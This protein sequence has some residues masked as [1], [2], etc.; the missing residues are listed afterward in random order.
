ML[1]GFKQI[2]IPLSGGDDEFF[3]IAATNCDLELSS[4]CCAEDSILPRGWQ[5]VRS[6]DKLPPI[7]IIEQ[8]GNF[9]VRLYETFPYD[10][11]TEVDDHS[12]D[13][14]SPLSDAG[15]RHWK[16]RK[17]KKSSPSGS[18]QVVNHLGSSFI[19]LGKDDWSQ[20]IPLEFIS[21]KL[22]FDVEY[23]KMTEDIAAFCE[24]LLLSATNPTSLK[25]S[26]NPDE[27][28]RLLLESF[29]FLRHFLTP[30]K[31]QSLIEHIHRNPHSSLVSERE[32][33]PIGRVRSSQHLSQPDKMLRDWRG[34]AGNLRP[35]EA[36]NVHRQESHNTPPNQFLK[37]AL[38]HFRKITQDILDNY[39]QESTIGREAEEL[40]DTLD[41]TL[42]QPF[43]RS[44][45]RLQ[46]L[47]LNNQT[48]Q[49]REGYRDV[50]RA[51]ILVESACSLDWAGQKDCFDGSTRDVATLYEYW[52]FLEI[53]KILE[54]IDGMNRL[55]GA[56]IAD[57]ASSFINEKNGAI[58]LN[59]QSGKHSLSSFEFKPHDES[60]GL[61]IDL[62]YER[63]FFKES[64]DKY[65]DAATSIASYSRQF[66]PDYTLAIFPSRFADEKRAAEVGKVAHL[67]FDAKY[68]ASKLKEMFGGKGS[69]ELS[70]EKKAVKSTSTY[71]RGDLLKMHTYNDALRKTIGSYVLYPGDG[72]G[73]KDSFNKFHE[74]A[75]SV[76]ALVMKPG[77]ETC[78]DT[79]KS[80]LLDVFK[81]QLNQF[82]Q[83]SY[84]RDARHDLHAYDSVVKEDIAAQIVANK[85]AP[86]V[87][88]WLKKEAQESFKNLGF[89]YCHAV[90]QKD[91]VNKAINLDLSIQ[92]GSEFVP[93][94]GQQG[95]PFQGLG[96]RAKITGAR[97]I[98]KEKLT[99]YIKQ[100]DPASA[101]KSPSRAEHYILYEFSD[102]AEIPHYDLAEAHNEA[103][104]GKG[105]QFMAV[106][107]TWKK[108]LSSQNRIES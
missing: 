48:L 35:T 93:C 63:T 39:K 79:L 81:H 83:Y 24:Q 7:Q 30:E 60:E 23:R 78:R 92:L 70:A 99:A 85:S 46:H 53:H 52:L 90:E 58:S 11:A 1:Q 51:W 75:P 73:S 102:V 57:G 20:T 71:Q 26:S 33:L 40:R 44:L 82:T 104:D 98:S 28:R 49:K 59:L 17:L 18:F 5:G 96:W 100:K 91:E 67:H 21:K 15:S 6:D 36:L 12:I 47:P 37:F 50:L 76:G 97:F 8:S 74:I 42:A 106:T 32:W 84:L 38:S 69:E 87:I 56:H 9:I 105:S 55:T 41:A 61:R 54:S 4:D 43:F 107:T 14:G 72:D 68:R 29:L 89:A 66:R 27:K 3:V 22:D 13:I 101:V 2:A 65:P 95:S 77:N 31:L 19:R 64:S 80:F 103:R 34:A 10:W 88:L 45:S 16:V 25:F 94:G 108:I 86:C 62:H